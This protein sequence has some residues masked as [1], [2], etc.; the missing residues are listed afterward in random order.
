MPPFL[1]P[2]AQIGAAQILAQAGE[3]DAAVDDL[4][5]MLG[6]PAPPISVYT[7]RLDPIWDPIR[8]NPRFKALLSKYAV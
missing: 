4:Q 3:A 7:L 5:R 8:D 2:F 1:G 6:D